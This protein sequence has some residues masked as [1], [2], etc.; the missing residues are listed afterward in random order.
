MLYSKE[1]TSFSKAL[2]NLSYL[3]YNENEPFTCCV[4][5]LLRL[6]HGSYFKLLSMLPSWEGVWPLISLGEKSSDENSTHNIEGFFLTSFWLLIKSLLQ[7]KFTAF[8]M[9]VQLIPDN[10]LR[11]LSSPAFQAALALPSCTRM[12]HAWDFVAKNT[13]QSR[14]KE[15]IIFFFFEWGAHPLATKAEIAVVLP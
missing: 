12:H 13:Q 2:L 3:I 8:H 9:D 1:K 6:T 11:E 10:L 7:G 4:C 5:C 15:S 14:S